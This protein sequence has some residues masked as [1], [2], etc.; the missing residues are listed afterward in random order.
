MIDSNV[1]RRAAQRAGE[2]EVFLAA[3]LLTYARA[4]RLDDAALAQHL[5]CTVTDLPALL[6]CRRPTGTTFD[7]NVQRLVNRFHVKADRL[8]EILRSA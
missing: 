1:L 6:L 7:A 4:V 2:Q 5:G 3:P 8:T